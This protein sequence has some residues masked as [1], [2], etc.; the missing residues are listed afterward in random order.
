[1]SRTYYY[2]IASLP[3]IEFD[4]KIPLS[5]QEYLKDCKNLLASEDYELVERILTEDENQIR[6][7]EK[8]LSH[9]N[10]ESEIPIPPV[11]GPDKYDFRC[12]PAKGGPKGDNA[13]AKR[14]LIWQ[15]W[16]DFNERLRNELAWFRAE[17]ASVDPLLHAQG[18]KS[19]DPHILGIIQHISQ[20]PNLLMA[21]RFLDQIRWKFL[22][23]LTFGQ[24]FNKELVIIYTL[25]LKILARYEEIYSD[26]GKEQFEEL[27]TVHFPDDVF[28]TSEFQKRNSDSASGGTR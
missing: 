17:R 19:K 28:V 25:K 18:E 20:E 26:K 21:E 6:A 9:R 15:A 14:V 8:T 13:R 5:L 16:I 4:S 23:E 1:M 2:F 10:F 11:A 27:K 3:R 7:G 22:E 24:Y 12:D